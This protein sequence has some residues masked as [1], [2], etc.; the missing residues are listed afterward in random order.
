[1]KK[2]GLLEMKSTND[3]FG[4]KLDSIFSAILEENNEPSEGYKKKTVLV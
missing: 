3:V 2:V 1:M 4:S